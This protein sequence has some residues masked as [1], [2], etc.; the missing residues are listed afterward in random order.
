MNKIENI[1]QVNTLISETY[2]LAIIAVIVALV[3]AF[4][5]AKLILFEGGKNDRSYMKRRIWY[6][7]IGLIAPVSFYLYNMFVVMAKIKKAPLQ[8]KFS[9]ANLYS[10]LIILVVYVVIGIITMMIFRKSKWGSILGKT[11]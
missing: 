3:L 6:I 9:D 11:K 4:F 7:I 8:A 2:M 5:I 1:K 10:T